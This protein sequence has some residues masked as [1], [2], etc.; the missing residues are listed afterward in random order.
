MQ[1][2]VE[3]LS[4]TV[5]YCV[6][7]VVWYRTVPASF[8]RVDSAQARLVVSAQR[9]VFLNGTAAASGGVTSPPSWAVN[10]LLSA[11]LGDKSSAPANGGDPALVTGLMNSIAGNE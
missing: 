3:G 9:E 5:P 7:H 2:T 8:A 1:V 6:A 4:T 11:V 10:E